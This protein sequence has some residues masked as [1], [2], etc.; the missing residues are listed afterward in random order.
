MDDTRQEALFRVVPSVGTKAVYGVMVV[1]IR[2]PYHFR[3]SHGRLKVLEDTCDTQMEDLAITVAK[4]SVLHV[5]LGTYMTI[6][7][8]R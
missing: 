2:A 4:F 1:T 3:F 5:C 8:C 6:N 7:I